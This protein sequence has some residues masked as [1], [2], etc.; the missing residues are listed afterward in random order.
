VSISVSISAFSCAGKLSVGP[1]NISAQNLNRAT[2]GTTLKG[3]I[4]QEPCLDG[5][6]VWS[7]YSLAMLKSIL[8]EFTMI[9]SLL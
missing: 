7:D 6:S 2:T 3:T 9:L 1:M 4:S 5:S 8:D